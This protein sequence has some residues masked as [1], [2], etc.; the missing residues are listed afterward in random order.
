M[1]KQTDPLSYRC[2]LPS[3]VTTK[4]HQDAVIQQDIVSEE[5]RLPAPSLQPHTSRGLRENSH[6][7]GASPALDDGPE[8]ATTSSLRRSAHIETGR[9]P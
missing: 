5:D 7:G 3:G 9:A 8:E 2:T 6:P 1:V 4:R